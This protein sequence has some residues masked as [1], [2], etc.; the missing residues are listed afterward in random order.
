MG[1]PSALRLKVSVHGRTEEGI[2]GGPGRR[3]LGPSL[4]GATQQTVAEQGEDNQCDDDLGFRSVP[5][6]T[7]PLEFKQKFVYQ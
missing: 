7:Y 5:A 2:F 1:K 3:A 6:M 4:R